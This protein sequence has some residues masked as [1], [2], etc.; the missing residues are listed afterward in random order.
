[1]IKQIGCVAFLGVV[2]AANMCDAAL[3]LRIN[4]ST[5]PAAINLIQGQQTILTI[6]LAGTVPD[7]PSD[8]ANAGI[9]Q[10]QINLDAFG[11]R[12]ETSNFATANGTINP[13]LSLTNSSI[14]GNGTSIVGVSGLVNSAN[15]PSLTNTFVNLATFTVTA[16]MV[17]ATTI[18]LRDLNLGGLG[19]DNLTTHGAGVG[20]FNRDP[21]IFGAPGGFS[22]VQVAL[23]VSPVPEPSSM[24]L[25]AATGAALGFR[26]RRKKASK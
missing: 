12:L 23:N 16:N 21:D 7:T 20:P 8:P 26:A 1:M 25:L 3:T 24:L 22:S 9:A 10:N 11:F 19:N 17:G 4:G 2:A 13:A 5:S 14:T 18:R 15:R 6:S